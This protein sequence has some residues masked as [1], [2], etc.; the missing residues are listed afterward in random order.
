M[1]D[2]LHS[3]LSHFFRGSSVLIE[4]ELVSVTF[5]FIFIAV[6]EEHFDVII[7]FPELAPLR[8]F[9]LKLVLF[10]HADVLFEGLKRACRA[11]FLC[12]N[13]VNK[14]IFDRQLLHFLLDLFPGLSLS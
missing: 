14:F 11:L 2:C 1:L 6:L 3:L 7:I 10:L 13:T 9:L 4:S 8:F 5:F 12:F